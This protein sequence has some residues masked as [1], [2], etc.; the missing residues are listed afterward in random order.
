MEVQ[1]ATG[2]IESTPGDIMLI[3]RNELVKVLKT[4]AEKGL[5]LK[6]INIF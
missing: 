6:S 4:P 3:R 1:F 5:P 2:K